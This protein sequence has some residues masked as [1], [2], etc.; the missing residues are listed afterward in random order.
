MPLPFLMGV[1]L[2]ACAVTSK[3]ALEKKEKVPK[4]ILDIIKAVESGF[5]KNM[6]VQWSDDNQ[7]IIFTADS[8]DGTSKIKIEREKSLEIEPNEEI[9]IKPKNKE[10]RLKIVSYLYEQGKTQQYIANYVK[11]SQKTI[12]N[13]IKE[14]KS[15]RV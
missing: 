4:D 2:V 9:S 12:S 11:T 13:D 15:Q 6:T 8:T 14:I 3:Q 5:F 7:K 10:D 1:S